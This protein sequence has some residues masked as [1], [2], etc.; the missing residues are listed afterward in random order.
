M[1]TVMLRS[2]KTTLVLG[3]NVLDS[4]GKILSYL[5]VTSNTTGDAIYKDSAWSTYQAVVSGTGAITATV[6]IFGSNDGVNFT[7]TAIG[8][9]TLT[10]TTVAN[11]GFA[12]VAPWKYVRAVLSNLTGTGAACYVLQGI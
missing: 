11:D 7:T 4:E 2:G 5:G 8:T 9:I 3:T 6:N 12:T 1:D 10:G